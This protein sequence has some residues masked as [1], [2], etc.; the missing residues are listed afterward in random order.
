MKELF[1]Q[2]VN[3]KPQKALF[4][5]KFQARNHLIA[6]VQ[7]IKQLRKARRFK[8]ALKRSKAQSRK[9]TF[10]VNEVRR[11]IARIRAIFFY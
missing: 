11:I 6:L 1:E 3:E 7:C 4:G 2:L 10:T 9:V 5:H 8:A